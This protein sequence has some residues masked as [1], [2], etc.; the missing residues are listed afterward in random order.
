MS[1]EMVVFVAETLQ[2][3]LARVMSTWQLLKSPE[4]G[5]L[6]PPFHLFLELTAIQR[7]SESEIKHKVS[8][9]ETPVD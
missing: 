6:F 7:C 5:A 4:K 9:K 3:V 8:D 1:I 2:T